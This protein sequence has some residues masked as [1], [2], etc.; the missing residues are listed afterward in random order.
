MNKPTKLTYTRI[1]T[2]K[3]KEKPYKLADGGGLFLL[4]NPNGS[5]LWRYRYRLDGKENL[6]ALGE[7]GTQ[8]NGENADQK[9][10]RHRAG[11]LTLSEAREKRAEAAALVKAG[12]HP[13]HA[14]KE[15]KKK[16]KAD[17]ALT[18]ETVARE[19]LER[20]TKWKPRTYRQREKILEADVFPELGDKPIKTI[21]RPD[22]N[23]LLVK[24]EKRAPQMA[25]IARQLMQSIFDHAEAV[26][27]VAE[28]VA[29]R[30]V[31]INKEK[32]THA[33]QLSAAEI[34]PFLLACDNYPGSYE[35][36]AAMA[37]AWLTL[38]RSTEVL[39]AEWAEFDLDA[40][41][42]RIPAG[43]M[44]ME[45]EHIIPLS[46]QALEL[47]RGLRAVSGKGRYLFPNRVDRSRPAS[48]GGLWKMVDSLGWRDRFS[49]HGLRGTASTLMNESGRWS[50]DVI[51]RLLAHTETNKSRASYNAAEYLPQR[52]EALRWWADLLDALKEGRD[53]ATV[54]HL[55]TIRAV[56]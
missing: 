32:T 30:L 50:A 4:V 38:A 28:S 18:F 55:P 56:A 41:L 47:L 21:T 29:L 20:Q 9:A 53:G 45:R 35:M 3:P 26:G 52:T 51:E 8:P 17:R 5:K 24:V 48:A 40:A 42:W 25:T 37:L 54:L 31:N 23:A 11:I 43:R 46:K 36:R 27:Y 33:R 10:I 7:Y 39:D 19:W 1:E 2:A 22:I 12:I 49:P 6:F 34:G 44:K 15:A 14:K 13:S 16:E